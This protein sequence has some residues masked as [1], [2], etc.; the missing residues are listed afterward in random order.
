MHFAAYPANVTL[1][2]GDTEAESF[3]VQP[4]VNK[5][6]KPLTPN[7]YIRGTVQRNGVTVIDFAPSTFWYTTTPTTYNF[8]AF[9]A[10]RAEL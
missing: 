6:F 4:G 10:Y 8:N 3:Q 1:W 9:T 5:L 2:T 7:S